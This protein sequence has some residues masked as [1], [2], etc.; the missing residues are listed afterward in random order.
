MYITMAPAGVAIAD[1]APDIIRR[2]SVPSATRAGWPIPIA[3]LQ[4]RNYLTTQPGTNYVSHVF[5]NVSS[6]F[7]DIGP[8]EAAVA[9]EAAVAVVAA[10]A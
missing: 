6:L 5:M 1:L 7:L 3:P 9:A 8:E 2:D 4:T 10:M